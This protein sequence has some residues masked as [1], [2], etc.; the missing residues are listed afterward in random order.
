M[1]MKFSTFT[2]TKSTSTEPVGRATS[3]Q[4]A[5]SGGLVIDEDPFS[6]YELHSTAMEKGN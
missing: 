5:P 1:Q 6:I 4:E 2:S 3:S